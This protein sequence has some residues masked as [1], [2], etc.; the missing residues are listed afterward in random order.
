MSLFFARRAQ[1]RLSNYV[2]PAVALACVNSSELACRWDIRRSISSQPGNSS[3]NR[4]PK[5]SPR[6]VNQQDTEIPLLGTSDDL[7]TGTKRT[8]GHPEGSAAQSLGTGPAPSPHRPLPVPLG[9][10]ASYRGSRP[11]ASSV[12]LTRPAGELEPIIPSNRN[13]AT[14]R[15]TLYCALVFKNRTTELFALFVSAKQ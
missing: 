4:S 14:P 11:R 2:L 10:H 1:R 5:I 8:A 12:T 15:N 7:L 9:F 3:A 13:I 6:S